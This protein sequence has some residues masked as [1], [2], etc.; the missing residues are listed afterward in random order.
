MTIT[1]NGEDVTRYFSADSEFFKL[2][3]GDNSVIY[4]D[5]VKDRSVSYKILW[6]DLWL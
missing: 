2:K 3:P 5:G 1:L 4:S 6:K